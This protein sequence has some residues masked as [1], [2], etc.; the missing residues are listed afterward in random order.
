MLT[1]SNGGT[2][3]TFHGDPSRTSLSSPDTITDAAWSPDGSQ[4]V[5]LDQQAGIK[6][7]RFNDG[8]TRYTVNSP[9]DDGVR[10]GSPTWWADGSA[11]AWSE[12]NSAS[13]LWRVATEQVGG[14]LGNSWLSPKDGKH[15]LNPDG[16]PG[17]LVA[18]QRQDDNGSGL[19]TG[20]PAVMLYDGAP[21][22]VPPTR[23]SSATRPPWCCSPGTR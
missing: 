11:V 23:A 21:Q 14:L 13:S 12:K 10:R 6:R 1:S 2:A 18:F 22:P 5:Y 19:P 8:A 20:Q 4:A 3:I 17:Q 16:G 15:Y 7:I 9:P